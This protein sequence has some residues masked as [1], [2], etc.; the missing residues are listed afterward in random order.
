ME[1]IDGFLG[2]GGRDDQAVHGDRCRPNSHVGRRSLLHGR[3]PVVRQQ[4]ARRQLAQDPAEHRLAADQLLRQDRHLHDLDARARRGHRGRRG[5]PEVGVRGAEGHVGARGER[6]PRRGA[7][8]GH[9]RRAGVR[10]AQRA[11]DRGEPDRRGGGR[12]AVGNVRAGARDRGRRGDRARR[13]AH[14]GRVGG[15]RGARGDRERE[16]PRS[17]AAFG[18]IDPSGATRSPTRGFT[19]RVGLFRL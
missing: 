4:G 3:R 6:D 18:L 7:P 2:T 11:A 15:V 16:L 12:R 9:R 14:R 13:D 17:E 19:V 1:S 5:A 10:A 8:P